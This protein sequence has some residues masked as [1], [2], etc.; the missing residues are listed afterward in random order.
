MEP[1]ENLSRV[2]QRKARVREQLVDA[3]LHAFN[4]MGYVKTTVTDITTRADVGYGTFYQYFRNKQDLLSTLADELAGK[5]DDYVHPKNQKLGVY[6]RITFGIRGILQCYIQYKDII[7]AI[8]E[9][10]MVDRQF[11]EKWAAIHV[12]LFRRVER[13]IVGSMKKGYCRNIDPDVTIIALTCMFEGYADYVMMQPIG[14]IDIDK[15]AN[16][17][18]DICYH[19]VFNEQS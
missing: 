9:A 1:S 8:K 3:A 6:E 17:L 19:A 10:M 18:T 7:V 12:I 14:S 16:S 13:D 4:E 11:E 15:T 5:V 2:E